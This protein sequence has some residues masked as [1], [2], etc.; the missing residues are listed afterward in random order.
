MRDKAVRRRRAVLAALVALSLG[1]LTAYFGES[2]SGG[3]HAVQRGAM[4][5][6][7]PIQEGADRAL[8]PF[9]DLFRWVGDTIDA[10]DERDRL[11]AERDR[12]VQE[13][14][15]LEDQRRENER[16]RGLV[17][18]TD[19]SDLDR[20]EPVTARVYERSHSTWWSR[21]K[22]NKGASDGL[23][24]D[25]PVVGPGGL[26][27]R[28][29]SVSDGNAVVTLITDQSFGISALAGQSG[30]PG[31]LE[32]PIGQPGQ[33][34][35]DL[36]E[37]PRR[38]RE[39]DRIVTAGTISERLPSLFPRGIPIGTVRRIEGEGELDR[40]ITVTPAADLGRLD[41][42]QVLTAPETALVAQR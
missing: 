32:Q 40:T 22:I 28:V 12:L 30:E 42:V 17:Q 16:L 37:N 39:G 33:L 10:Q 2:A 7:A 5:V 41:L 35:L 38:I 18:L 23:R 6:L 14:A 34:R 31:V 26:V 13:V 19:Q 20:F 24:A 21:V 11:R 8:K 29:E 15:R 1:L 27:G 4:E 3:L 36:V 9:R 25:Q